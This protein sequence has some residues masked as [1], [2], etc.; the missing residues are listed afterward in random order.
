[1]SSVL[2]STAARNWDISSWGAGPEAVSVW[3]GP[4]STC[5]SRAVGSTPKNSATSTITIAPMP[6]T[7]PTAAGRMPRR[8]STLLLRLRSCHRIV[9]SPDAPGQPA[10]VLQ[11]PS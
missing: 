8:S 10:A 1:V 7:P 11:V 6:P 2:P 4:G 3:D 9:L 5:C